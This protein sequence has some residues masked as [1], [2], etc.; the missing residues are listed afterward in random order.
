MA[1]PHRYQIVPSEL[2][3]ARYLSAASTAAGE[4]LECQ[5]VLLTA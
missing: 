2:V 3:V 5:R 1:C 4:Y